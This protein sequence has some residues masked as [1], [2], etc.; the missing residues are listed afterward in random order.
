MSM[1]D[2]TVNTA[3]GTTIGTFRAEVGEAQSRNFPV[4]NVGGFESAIARTIVLSKTQQAEAIEPRARV[5]LHNA[6]MVT[7]RELLEVRRIKANGAKIELV[8]ARA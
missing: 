6:P 4:G 8:A 1:M 2:V 3:K 5:Q 7:S